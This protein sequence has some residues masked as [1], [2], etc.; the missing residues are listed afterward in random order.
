MANTKLP[1]AGNVTLR[2]ALPGWSANPNKPTVAEVN[3][4][5]DVTESASWSDFGFGNQASNQV[6]DPSLADV[7]NTQTRG[8]AQFGGTVSFIYPRAYGNAADANSNTFEA[9]DQPRTL[10]Y[11]LMRVDGKVTPAGTRT[12]INGDFWSIYKVMTDG[13]TDVVIGENAFR[14]TVTFLPQGDLWVNAVVATAAPTLT[15][16]LTG[17]LTLT[18]TTKKPIIAYFTGRQLTTLGYPGWFSY[19]S[20]DTTKATVDGNGLVRGVAAGNATI[21]VTDP[22]SLVTTTV[23]PIV[24]T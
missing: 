6:S 4:T 12:A 24:V 22:K 13:W 8:F 15:A 9:M 19:T 23:G 20:S 18:T 7:G 16:S 21:T 11:L 14:Y 10:G 5:L 1:A 17:G 3:A 2:W